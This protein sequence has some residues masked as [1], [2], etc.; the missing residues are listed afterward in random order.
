M[1]NALS[2][3]KLKRVDVIHAGEDTF[4]LGEKIRALSWKRLLIDLNRL[5]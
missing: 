2:D 1:R 4:P 3:L 5:D